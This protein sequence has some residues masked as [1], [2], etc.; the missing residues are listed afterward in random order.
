MSPSKSV[1]VINERIYF[2]VIK[3]EQGICIRLS[4]ENHSYNYYIISNGSIT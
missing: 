3:H 2:K 1:L 4:Y